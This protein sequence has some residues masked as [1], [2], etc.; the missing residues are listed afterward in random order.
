MVKET[1]YY[2]V[3]GVK[4]NA[5]QDELKKAYRK[6]ALKYHPD[7][8]PNEGEKFKQISQAYEVL[9]DAKKRDLYDK[10]GEQAIKE[11]GSGGG[12]GSPMDI[13]DMFFGG[14]GRMQRE[15]RGKN[16]VHQLSVNLEDLYNGAT[17]KLA[18]QKN[19]ICDKCEGRG[20]KKGAV[21]CCPN[22]RGTG[23]QIR[24]HQIGPGMVQQIQSVCMECQGH[25]ER[26]S[27]KDRCKSC[28]GRK[29]VR[30][31]KILEVHID[32]GMKDGQKI[33]FHGEGDQEPGLEP[34]DIIIVLDQKDNTVFTRRGEDL[35]MCMDI[36]LVEAL[37]GFQKP[38]STLDNR[39]IIITSQ[40]G[41]IIKHGDIK[42]V[43]NEGMPIY[44]RPYEK[45]RLIIE[46]KVNF[47]ES[48]FLSSD[49]LSLL[50]KLLP[51]RKEVEESE[52][53][54]QVELLDFDPA[55]ERRRHY[56]GEAY[57]D[58]EHHPRATGVHRIF[59]TWDW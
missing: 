53:M 21:E 57:E 15:R 38:I 56:N 47:P 58:D 44:R 24:I 16:V 17:R 4:P 59:F 55:Q 19:V 32:K 7:K 36:Q 20:G 40:P 48:G 14:G 43:L 41:S 45:G 31:K 37:C 18:L 22:C 23:M 10:G 9:S 12:F 35:F 30:E 50:E 3:L 13:F 42:C 39:T 34:G 25:G 29:I 11:G 2:D 52:E 5:S 8:N 54:D 27:P 46:F 1:T 49:K 51:E 26:I 33:T 6:L 28:N